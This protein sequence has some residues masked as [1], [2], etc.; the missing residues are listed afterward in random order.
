VVGLTGKRKPQSTTIVRTLGSGHVLLEASAPFE[1]TTP[2]KLAMHKVAMNKKF[3]APPKM[4]DT[5]R[6]TTL[7][8][9]GPVQEPLSAKSAPPSRWPHLLSSALGREFYELVFFEA[10]SPST[11]AF[12]AVDLTTLQRL[13]LYNLQHRLVVL[14]REIAIAKN[15]PSEVPLVTMDNVHESLK[16]YCK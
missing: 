8:A 16:C 13:N 1:V 11:P 12:A 5:L 6:D 9:I 2:W 3:M 10:K 14:V 7:H 15:P 4:R